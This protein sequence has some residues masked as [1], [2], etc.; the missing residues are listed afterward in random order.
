MKE[1][2][3]LAF[4]SSLL[5]LT[6]FSQ[7]PK[8]NVVVIVVDD[9]ND[10]IE[11]YNGQ[12]Q[13]VTPA[14]KDLESRGCTFTNGFANAP[15]CAPS[16]TSFL[17][18][19]DINYTQVFNNAD[20]PGHFREAFVP[21]KNNDVVYT[22]PEILKDSGGYYTYCINKIFHSDHEG[23]FDDNMSHDEC[24]KRFSW[25]RQTNIQESDWF[26][27]LS[28]SYAQ[29]HGSTWGMI[30]DS[31][32]KYMQDVAGT[33]SAIQFI[34]NYATGV[35]DACGKPF[36][37]AMG[38]HR[39]HTGRMI[40]EKYF[41]PYYSQDMYALPSGLPYNSPANA[42]PPNGIVMPPQP[43]IKYADYY[44]FPEGG[45][46]RGVAD[47]GT[48]E[49]DITDYVN[50]LSPLPVISDTMT[51][52]ERRQ[53]ITDVQIANHASCYVAAV[54]FIDTQLGRLMAELDAH[55]DVKN[56]TIIILVSDHGYALGEKKH[57]TKW[58]LWETDIRIPFI[59]IDPS[60]SGAVINTNTV[61][62]L[63][64]FPTVLDITDTPE[65]RFADGTPYLDGTSILPLFNDA[66]LQVERP[67]LTT[68]KKENEMALCFPMY[69]VR[70]ERFH[71]IRYRFNS[72]E[73]D[74]LDCDSSSST[75]EKE[76]YELGT[77]REIDPNEWNNMASDADYQPLIDYLE[78]FLPDSM[79]YM[80]NINKAVITADDPKPCFYN[81]P[82]DISLHAA[83]YTPE[84]SPISGSALSAYK[85]TWTNNLTSEIFTGTDFNF[86]MS[87][88][89]D[90]IFDVKDKVIFY[91][92]VTDP[93]SGQLLAF[94]I[95][96]YAINEA[97]IPVVSY[98]AEVTGGYDLNI[99]DYAITGD[100]TS[101]RWDFGD[102]TVVDD[103]IPATH[104]YTIPGIYLVQNTVFYGN[105]ECSV[106]TD[107]VINIMYTD[108]NDDLQKQPSINVYPSPATSVVHVSAL[109]KNDQYMLYIYD[110]LG[111]QV[112]YTEVANTGTAVFNISSLP[113]GSYIVK[114][115]SDTG[116]STRKFEIIR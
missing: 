32:E 108:I 4:F 21:E 57:Y 89:A 105:D 29:Y 101:T 86:N 110:M 102:G 63:D 92:H 115:V 111:R 68:Y 41:L 28:L 79:F 84:G 12:P 35:E 103:L 42:Y 23:D 26:T 18:G 81:K 39:P 10:Y 107:T 24:D 96:S 2:V 47:F 1:K 82:D 43:A 56:N 73:P 93:A 38:Y 62:L 74:V 98:D 69:S 97:N 14:F 44:A 53:F 67:V 60:K 15:G 30:P 52:D 100:Y 59:M 78:D 113:Q 104:T 54:Q 49:D 48:I 13:I 50:S 85:F 112:M 20:Y 71:Y 72:D 27:M 31:L 9:L 83:L 7:A 106:I 19:K 87:T 11:G 17:S 94:D 46:A 25:N 45:I 76:L 5:T 58:A 6:V 3:L 33:D 116:Y 109:N 64:L 8:P 65:P 114:A 75:Y 61:D 16:R 90:A 91:L 95:R 37:L 36:F 88:V 34:K 22:L 70:T 40:P 80:R 66:D 55:P 51:D 77:D 99:S